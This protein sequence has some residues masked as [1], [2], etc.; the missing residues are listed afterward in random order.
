MD[1]HWSVRRHGADGGAAT[2]ES[3]R[4]APANVALQRHR[5]INA[6]TPVHGSRLELRRVAVGY[7][8]IHG[9][10]RRPKVQPWAAPLIAIERHVQ[11]AV[12][13]LASYLARNA[14]EIDRAIHRAEL[15]SRI[16]VL[17]ADSAILRFG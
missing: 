13:R 5:E 8:Q 4:D 16:D 2:P 14:A 9:A 11:R 3:R 1:L 10:V 12:G 17:D 15:E 6:H 7:F